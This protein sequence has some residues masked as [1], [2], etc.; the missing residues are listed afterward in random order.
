MGRNMR[1]ETS[2]SFHT[3]DAALQRVYDAAEAKCRGN[4]QSFGG[5]TVLVEGGG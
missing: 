5:R 3:E 4:L 1:S 2:V